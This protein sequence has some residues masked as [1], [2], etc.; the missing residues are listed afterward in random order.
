VS[1]ATPKLRGPD[2]KLSDERL[3]EPSET[4]HQR[5]EATREIRHARFE[6][7]GLTCNADMG[8]A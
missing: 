8:V 7:K 6:G 1:T 4:I 3:G 5:V 2:D